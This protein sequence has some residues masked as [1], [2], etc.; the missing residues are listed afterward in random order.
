VHKNII[1]DRLFAYEAELKRWSPRI[2]LVAA[3]TIPFIKRRHIADAEQ[4]ISY[5]RMDDGIVDIGSGAGF[6]GMVLAMHGYSVTLVESD[7]KK[8]I[9]L[10]H[11]SRETNTPVE[12]VC[13]RAEHFKPAKEIEIVTARAVASLPKLLDLCSSFVT[14]GYTKGLFLKGEKAPLEAKDLL[15]QSDLFPSSVTPGSYIVQVHF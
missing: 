14:S 6:P 9:F 12:I 8:C 2:N 5:L 15:R 11:V 13:C 4:L 3:S 1:K 7:E 10:R